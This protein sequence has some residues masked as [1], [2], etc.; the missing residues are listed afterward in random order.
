MPNKIAWGGIDPGLSGCACLMTESEIHFHDFTDEKAA[1]AKIDQ[2]H[3]D[4]RVWFLLEKQ[5]DV[6]KPGFNVSGKL[7][8]NYGF[9]KGV[10]IGLNCNFYEKMPKQ[11]RMIMPGKKLNGEDTKD[12]SLRWAR[13]FYPAC[14]KALSLKKYHNRA[15]ALLMSHFI[16]ETEIQ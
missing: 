2:W 3:H 12:M 13:K 6:R 11:W 16:R 5:V 14:E 10:L 7:L 15:D 1:A 9:W 8:I 4:F